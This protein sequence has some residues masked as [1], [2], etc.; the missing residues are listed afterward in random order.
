MSGKFDDD[1]DSLY[2]IISN[3]II[4]SIGLEFAINGNKIFFKESSKLIPLSVYKQS[5]RDLLI[6]KILKNEK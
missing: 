5:H 1:T 3:Y 2:D 6:D 4:T